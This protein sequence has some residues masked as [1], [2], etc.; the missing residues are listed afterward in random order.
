[1]DVK[2][3]TTSTL[4]LLRISE[5]SIAHRGMT[6]PQREINFTAFL[7]FRL[8]LIGD[9]TRFLQNHVIEER[10]IVLSEDALV[11]I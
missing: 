3:S 4:F 7:F 8:E 5:I 9:K 1:M 2:T 10:G 6:D 11:F